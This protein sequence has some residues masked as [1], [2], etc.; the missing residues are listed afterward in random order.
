MY[1]V[2]EWHCSMSNTANSV[3]FKFSVASLMDFSFPWVNDFQFKIGISLS[4]MHPQQKNV[5]ENCFKCQILVH[6]HHTH[7]FP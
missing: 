3:K 7:G 2:M 5:N 1:F 6:C 4:L